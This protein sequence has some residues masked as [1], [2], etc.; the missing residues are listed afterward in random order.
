MV[1]KHIFLKQLAYIFLFLWGIGYLFWI[2]KIYQ[3]VAIAVAV[4][5]YCYFADTFPNISIVFSILMYLATLGLC[6]MIVETCKMIYEVNE[7]ELEREMK[8]KGD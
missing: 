7:M 4:I 3:P 5:F 8:K 2:T 6:A 1:F